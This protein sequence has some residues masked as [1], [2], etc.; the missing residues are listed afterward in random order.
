MAFHLLGLSAQN[1]MTDFQLQD[2]GKMVNLPISGNYGKR[3][4]DPTQQARTG[5]ALKGDNILHYINVASLYDMS[6]RDYMI[7]YDI[8]DFAIAEVEDIASRYRDF[9]ILNS[10][11]DYTDM[12][13]MAKTAEL[14]LPH[15]KYLFIDEA[16]D[17]STLLWV[18]VNRMAETTEHI[19]IAGDDKQSINEFAGADV[20]TFLSIPGKVE[21]LEQSYRTP[22]AV[23][24]LA[25]RL[26][27]KMSQYRPEGSNWKPRAEVGYVRRCGNNLPI[28]K[29]LSGEW[30]VLARASYQLEAVR[31]Q[32]LRMSDDGA[33]L[34]TINGG[35]P[36][37]LD[38]LRVISLFK[39]AELK[40]PEF[41]KDMVTILD[42]HTI[43]QRKSRMDYIALLKKFISCDTDKKLQPWEITPEF[44]KKLE[45]PWAKAM[46]KLPPYLYQYIRKIYPLYLEKGENLF[47]DAKIRLM[48]IHAAKGREADNVILV[49]DLPRTVVETMRY[50]DTD[51]EIKTLYVAVTRAKKNLYFFSKYPNRFS[52][53]NY[54]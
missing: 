34:F 9:K 28:L 48:T 30:L 4:A 12:L 31:E 33:I 1:L 7:K 2:F 54:V 49:T 53:L 27:A 11:Y 22:R 21:V 43:E 51:T 8:H 13:K 35:S 25:N 42:S 36:I 50:G 14:N 17:L 6:I 26:M 52:Y 40:G 24:S 29:M 23:Y 10:I 19:I 32:L 47:A 18:L 37:D 46:D 3:P 45:L 16:Q 5:K 39:E 20:N 44:T 38:A 15:W 41:L